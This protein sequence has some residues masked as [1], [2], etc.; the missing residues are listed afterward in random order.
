MPRLTDETLFP[1]L[2]ALC[3]MDQYP[4]WFLAL[5][6]P[7]VL[8]PVATVVFYLFGNLHPF[9]RVESPAFSFLIYLLMQLFWLLPIGSFFGSLFLWGNLKEHAAI[10]TA[11]V[12]LL[13]S[14]TSIL[15]I[16]FP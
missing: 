10:I 11:V 12:G 4:K 9:G 5:I 8:I 1:L 13:I 7:N 16:L 2:H 3:S 15:L 14:L 6:F